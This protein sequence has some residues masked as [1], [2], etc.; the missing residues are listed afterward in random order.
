M[1]EPD[2]KRVREE[3]VGQ[4]SSREEE[5][6]RSRVEEERRKTGEQKNRRRG[7]NRRGEETECRSVPTY[8]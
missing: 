5:Q 1:G 4:G 6:E 2:S 3:Q 7:D 8:V